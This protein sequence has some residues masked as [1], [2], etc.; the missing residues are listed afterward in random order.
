[1]TGPDALEADEMTS[2]MRDITLATWLSLVGQMALLI[3]FLRAL[4]RPLVEVL[5]LVIGL[6]WTFGMVTLTVGHLNLLSMI[7]AP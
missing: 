3:I 5:C 7:F 4:R 1:M 2:A 6:C